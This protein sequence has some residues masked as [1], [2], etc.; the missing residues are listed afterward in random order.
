MTALLAEVE[1]FAH[2]S[3]RPPHEKPVEF[4]EVAVPLRFR[5]H[6]GV[7]SF[8]STVTVFGTAVDITLA[9]ISIEAFFP[10][11]DTTEAALRSGGGAAAPRLR[12]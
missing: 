5:T 4:Q 9:E 6:G 11:D 10:A 12:P 8:L 3:R 7:L 1:R 2:S